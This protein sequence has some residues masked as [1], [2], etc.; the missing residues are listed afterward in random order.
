MAARKFAARAKRKATFAG[1]AATRCAD[2]GEMR[3]A[4]AAFSAVAAAI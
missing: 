2:S 4:G 3:A 1:P